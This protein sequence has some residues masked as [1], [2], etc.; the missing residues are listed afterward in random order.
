MALP[1]LVNLDGALV[2]PAEAKVSVLD[3]G[4]LHGDSA[5]EVVRTYHQH[6]FELDLHLRRLAHSASRLALPLRWSAARTEAELRRTIEAAARL[7][8]PP[9]DPAAAPWNAGEW[10]ARIVMTRGAG[11]LGL[12]PALAADPLAVILLSPLAGPPARAYA[13]GVKVIVASTPRPPPEAVDPTAKTGSRLMHVLAVAEARAAGAHEALLR[14]GA[15]EVTEGC[16]SNVFTVSE[17]RLRTPP[18]AAGILEGVTR[19]AVLA[20]ARAEGVPVVEA[21]LR[22]EDLLGAEEVFI[23]STARELLPVTRIGDAAVGNG[24]PGPVTA[25]LHRAFRA[26]ADRL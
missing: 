15:G 11:E 19:G 25:R 5:Y 1:I 18:L 21:R 6:P 14:N 10:S 16:S 2:P 3:R 20:V 22:P 9:G 8:A 17:G 7:P 23:T 13:E 4:F 24:R 12:D 26:L